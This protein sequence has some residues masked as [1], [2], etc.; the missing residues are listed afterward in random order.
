MQKVAVLAITKHGVSVG[1]KLLKEFPKWDIHAPDK[2]AVSYD[3]DAQVRWYSDSTSGK[4]A[5][6]FAKYDGLVCLFSLGATIRLI[7]PHMKSKK[8]DPAVLVIDEMANF[9]ISVLSGHIGGA[10]K[11]AETIA[12]RLGA[13]AVI[14]TAADVKNTIAVDMIGRDQKWVIEDD[15]AVT[16]ASALMVN[17]EKIAMYQD[18]GKRVEEWYGRKKLPANVAT[19]DTLEDMYDSD[20]K[21][22]LIIT[23]RAVNA[24]AAAAASPKKAVVIYRPPTLIVGVGVHYNTTSQTIQNGIAQTFE[25]YGLATK[26]IAK[27][28]SIK[29]PA[30][31]PGLAQA[32]EELGVLLQLYDRKMLAD[33]TV[34]N[35]SNTVQSFEGTPSV[36]EAS[37]IASGKCSLIVEKQKFPP[38]LTIAVARATE[39]HST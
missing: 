28:T 36:S 25:K 15:S 37:C 2:F 20:A 39:E 13:Q 27:I 14:T 6:L 8:T 19:Y 18:A 3:N 10:N 16:A 12:Q 30:D 9:V 1:L 17:E 29:K 26:S 38:D 5:G 4:I 7:A 33:I 11:L 24:E 22:C 34:P 21:A 35:P 32:A 31:V 23:D